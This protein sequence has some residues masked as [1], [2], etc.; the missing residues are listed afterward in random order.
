MATNDSTCDSTNVVSIDMGDFMEMKGTSTVGKNTQTK[1]TKLKRISKK[2]QTKEISIEMTNLKDAIFEEGNFFRFREIFEIIFHDLDNISLKNCRNVCKAWKSFID[3]DKFIWLKRIEKYRGSMEKFSY[4]WS[5]VIEKTPTG[6]V[7][8]LCQAVEN[9]FRLSSSNIKNQYSPLHIAAGNGLVELSERIIEKTGNCNPGGDGYT[10]LH[11]AAQEGHLN[12]CELIIKKSDD[13]N[14]KTHDR[15]ITPLHLAARKGH[16]DV[17]R[18]I[19]EKIVVKNPGTNDGQTPLHIAAR[20]GHLDVCRLILEDENVVDKNPAANEGITPFHSAA[21]R[22]H[23]DV[24]RLIL[25][26]ENVVDKNPG[27]NDGIT[28]LH[29][30]SKG[31][32]LDVCKLILENENVVDKNPAAHNGITPLHIAAKGG[33]LDILKLL[34]GSGVDKRPLFNGRTPLEEATSNG[35]LK[36]CMFLIGNWRDL[37]QLCKFRLTGF[38]LKGKCLCLCIRAIV[39]L[40][41][42]FISILGGLF[43]NFLL[44]KIV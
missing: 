19:L 32:H 4:Q 36:S 35:H 7:N 23:L 25:E 3:T 9:F 15:E 42:L 13:K 12:V 40:V 26:D 2:C 17:C 5:K 11:T 44:S 41:M 31:G 21:K 24:C 1:K 29:N 20:G 16:F 6:E 30:A 38:S 28:P 8:E 22:G 14:P 10:A 39:F 33:H 18:L 34:V 43:V 37:E 27:T